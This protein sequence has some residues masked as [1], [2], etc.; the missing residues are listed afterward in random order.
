[1]AGFGGARSSDPF[2]ARLAQGS[3]RARLHRGFWACQGKGL[4]AL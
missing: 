2:G 3:K 1:M 4:G